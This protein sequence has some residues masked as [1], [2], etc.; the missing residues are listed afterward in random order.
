MSLPASGL[1]LWLQLAGLLGF[2]AVLLWAGW[3]AGWRALKDNGLVP[4]WFAAIALVAFLWSM[5]IGVRDGLVLH[6]LG[7]ASL[8]LI[9]GPALAI[10][11][12]AGALAINIVAG[13]SALAL[14][15]V[16]GLLLI[17]LP[18]WVAYQAHHQL[19]RWLPLNPFVFFLGS[20]FLGGML[21]L[22]APILVSAALLWSFD[23]HPGWVIWEDYLALLP[24]MLFPEGFI[25]GAVMTALAVWQPHWVR[26]F[27]DA[28]YLR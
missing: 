25:N 10:L 9:F 4:V 16:H 5:Q 2:A 20:G 1:P 6:L 19:R 3:F 8:V 13:N 24:L 7:T 17:A 14:A 26:T 22:A 18:V 23:V 21:A 27:D 15:G 28:E 11:A 12:F